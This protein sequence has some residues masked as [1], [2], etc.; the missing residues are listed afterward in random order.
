[1]HFRSTL[2]PYRHGQR[3]FPTQNAQP[4]EG[5]DQRVPT[6]PN[7]ETRD[8]LLLVTIA[9]KFVHPALHHPQ[10][11]FPH[12]L[13]P[14]HHLHPTNFRLTSI[15]QPPRTLFQ[16]HQP[17][18]CRTSDENRSAPT[19][20]R[21]SALP[22]VLYET[23]SSPAETQ[24]EEVYKISRPIALNSNSQLTQP[25]SAAPTRHRDVNSATTGSSK[26]AALRR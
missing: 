17:S 23:Q 11:F 5:D 20:H 9:G 12:R 19:S 6:T 24:E 16:G 3:P 10:P 21:E 2:E 22:L 7:G 13:L 8:V 26:W 18:S 1:M 14:A 25:I 15:C 4:Y